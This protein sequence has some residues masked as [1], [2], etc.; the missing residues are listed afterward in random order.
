MSK[1]TLELIDLSDEDIDL[2]ISGMPDG[3]NNT[4]VGKTTNNTDVGKTTHNLMRTES[5]VGSPAN[6]SVPR[7]NLETTLTTK[8]PISDTQRVISY[9]SAVSDSNSGESSNKRSLDNN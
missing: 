9:A 2:I 6:P 8:G 3:T 5:S 1:E 4:G 7:D